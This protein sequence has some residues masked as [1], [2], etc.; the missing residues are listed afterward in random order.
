MLSVTYA[1]PDD[2]GA[3]AAVLDELDRYYGASNVTSLGQR[4]AE[5]NAAVFSDPSRGSRAPRPRLGRIGRLC[6]VPLSLA[7]GR[8]HSFALTR[9]VAGVQPATRREHQPGHADRC[10]FGP[11]GRQQVS[12]TTLADYE[13]V[14]IR[15][16][17]RAAS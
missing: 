5:I 9:P 14:G 10:E 16:M 8:K 13:R 7:C 15:S 12:V 6:H 11:V 4:I 1:T 3:I 17:A 2:V